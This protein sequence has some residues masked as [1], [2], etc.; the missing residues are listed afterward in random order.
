MWHCSLEEKLQK[1]SIQIP[2]NTTGH[3]SSTGDSTC[4]LYE[5]QALKAMSVIDDV[6]PVLRD[7]RAIKDMLRRRGSS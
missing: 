2:C 1:A 5:R 4:L 3:T 7:L 6:L